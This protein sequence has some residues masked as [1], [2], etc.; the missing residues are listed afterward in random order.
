MTRRVLV[1][2]GTGYVG[3]RLIP[4]LEERG[5]DVRCLARRPEFLANRV[6][7]GTAVV[8]G[9]NR[10]HIMVACDE[11]TNMFRV[12]SHIDNLMKGQG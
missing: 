2:G 4:L 12:V 5:F 7:E 10:C 6:R 9:A 3:G 8:R 1:T 11:R